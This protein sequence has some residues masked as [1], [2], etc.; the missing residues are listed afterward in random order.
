MPVSGLRLS[1]SAGHLNRDRPAI[2]NPALE[3]VGLSA[4]DRAMGGLDEFGQALSIN[5]FDAVAVNHN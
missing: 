4:A 3:W 5:D 2:K 1:Q